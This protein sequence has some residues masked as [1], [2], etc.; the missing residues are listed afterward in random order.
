MVHE[1]AD[2]RYR[3]QP[4][5]QVLSLYGCSVKKR[6]AQQAAKQRIRH[7]AQHHTP[8]LSKT[9]ARVRKPPGGSLPSPQNQVRSERANSTNA[10]VHNITCIGLQLGSW[11]QARDP[12]R[13][14]NCL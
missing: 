1:A 3:A 9:V 4:E 2:G 12:F 8:M 5:R 11:K 6:Q 14:R 7:E 10:P 13:A